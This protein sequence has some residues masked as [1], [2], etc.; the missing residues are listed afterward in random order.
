MPFARLADIDVHYEIAGEGP[1]LTLSHPL[2][3]DLGMWA[4]QMSALTANFRVLRF[5]TRGHGSTSATPAPYTL[6]QLAD[7]AA[8]L[9]DHLGIARTHWLGLS[10]GGM[11][12]Q[13]LA[14]RRP[15]LLD[16]LVLADSTARRPANAAAM[17]A[18]RCVQA[19]GGGMAS[20]VAPTLQRWFTM[21]YATAHPE[22]LS[23]IGDVVAR[24]AVEG[25]CGCAAAIA[26]IDVLDRL[27]EIKSPALIMVGE[28]D[29]ATPPELSEQ[30]SRH[31]PGSEYC[32]IPGAAHAG[33]I[34]Q[35]DFFNR[36]VLDFL[37]R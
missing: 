1:W 19:R 33:N 23:W 27:H 9:L 15:G 22:T 2:A 25:Y 6:E 18:E 35:A 8:A 16:R 24:T 13:V 28:H 7:D 26:R 29:H 10:M 11:I 5:D 20:L 21:A 14:L 34:E 36:R 17:W 4:P 37:L 32:V 12:G 30:M 3:G 31:W